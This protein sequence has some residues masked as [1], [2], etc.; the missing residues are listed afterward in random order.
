MN[1]DISAY[2]P[3]RRRVTQ[4][5][6]R[7]EQPFFSH[8]G[9]ASGQRFQQ[10]DFFQAKLAIGQPGDQYEKEADNVA[11]AVV[12]RSEHASSQQ[13]QGFFTIQRRA[14]HGAAT[15][16]APAGMAARLQSSKGNGSRLPKRTHREMSQSLGFDFSD[17]RL[18]TDSESVNLNRAVGAQAFTHGKDIYFNSGKYNPGTTTGKHL[19]AHELTHVVQQNRGTGG[20]QRSS[21]IQREIELDAANVPTGNYLFR[22]GSGITAGFFRRIKRFVGD[23]A[24]T[25]N[26][27]NA[28]RI[29]ALRA[30][31]S[32]TNAERLLTAAMLN[33]VNVPLL[34]AHRS[35]AL[36]IVITTITDANRQH[37]RDIGREQIP[38]AIMLQLW[39]AV[40][41][42]GFDLERGLALLAE[43]D[44]AATREIL[45]HAGPQ[46]QTQ[47]AALIAY[48][49]MHT[50]L[51]LEV[52]G[53]M[54]NAASDSSSGDKVMAGI[55]YVIARK[56]GHATTGQIRNGQIK[57]DALIPR[58]YRRITSGDGSAAF[59]SSVG[60]ADQDKGDTL[61][62]PTN[63]NVAS[64]DS[65]SL[66][67]HELT[68]AADDAASG[69]ITYQR[70]L[71]FE[72]RARTRQLQYTM[73]EIL[74]LPAA[75]RP[76][77]IREYRQSAASE[78]VQWALILAT[79]GDTARYQ[80]ICTRILL[81][82]P[83]V[84]EANVVAAL[85]LSVADITTRLED[86]I[87]ELPNYARGTN[88]V[89]DGL[90][91]ES[92][93]DLVGAAAGP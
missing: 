90:S 39:D 11:T 52:L 48:M 43:V 87:A 73:D 81:Q 88:V 3:H 91:G 10:G 23:G 76:A 44:A 78:W 33:P 69:G 82:D 54:L 58:A 7:K 62:L 93:L 27:L 41:T 55:V 25:D 9:K 20:L 13:Q 59:Y 47:A 83:S 70:V 38:D 64:I 29:Y 16:Y 6:D 22:V 67:I 32:V 14:G 40:T 84:S 35:G 63:L 30:R 49:Q 34:Q 24:L 66:V 45:Q 1:R 31:G 74:A 85:A 57:V 51:A 5:I 75:G 77:V 36:S 2:R 72:A 89:L 68:H 53:A 60:R 92:V 80:E 8:V 42:L 19:L 46:F 79:K 86:A 56:A 4:G 28:L 65:R 18:H 61:Y 50:I 71:E 21:M 12:Q 37:A 26:E 15:P 17:V